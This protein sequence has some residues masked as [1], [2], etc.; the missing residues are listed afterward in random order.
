MRATIAFALIFAGCTCAEP[1]TSIPEYDAPR[2]AEAPVI[3]GQLD[4]AIWSTAPRTETFVSTMT[5]DPAA[6][7]SSAQIAWDDDNL[8][9][10]FEVE[11]DW[12]HCDLTGHDPHLW[13]QDTVE[14][15]VDP[16]SDGLNYFE[17]AA[18]P[19]GPGLRH[20]LRQPPGTSALRTGRLGQRAARRMQR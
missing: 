18:L 17:I 10:A 19:D 2:A 14:I 5:G 6:P 7:N 16:D 8:Y 1:R 15:M 11:D 12:L 9:V 4:D 13:E 3:D 20:P